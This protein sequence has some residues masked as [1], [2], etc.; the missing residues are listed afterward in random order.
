MTRDNYN[1]S[2][3]RHFLQAVYVEHKGAEAAQFTCLTSTTAQILT[4]KALLQG[5]VCGRQGSGD[6]EL[7]QT[8]GAQVW[9]RLCD[10][11]EAGT[12]LLALLVQEYKH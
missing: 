3:S 4:Q 9:R 2:D 8:S 5:R 10:A 7:G 6:R 12:H 11:R 1:I